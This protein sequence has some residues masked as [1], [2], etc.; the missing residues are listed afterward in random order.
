VSVPKHRD[1]RLWSIEDMSEFLGVLVPI[2][3]RWRTTGY[4]PRV[5]G[6]GGTSAISKRLFTAGSGLSKGAA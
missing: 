5:F 1:D 3:Y 6:S 4:G 2:L